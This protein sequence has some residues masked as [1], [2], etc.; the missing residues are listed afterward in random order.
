[1]IL[2]WPVPSVTTER[3]FSMSAGLDASTTTPGSTA[4]EASLTTPAIVAWASAADGRSTTH[5]RAADTRSSLRILSFL[6]VVDR[7]DVPR[8][9]DLA[10]EGS[11]ALTM[12]SMSR[13]PANARNP[14]VILTLWKPVI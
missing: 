6:F 7:T 5:A 14:L 1:M 9:S 3:T 10:A 13:G 8:V 2:Y 4:P 12:M 11:A